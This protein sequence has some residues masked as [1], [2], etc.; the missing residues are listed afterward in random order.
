MPSHIIAA[1]S[2]ETM[3]AVTLEALAFQVMT[4]RRWSSTATMCELAWTKY[5][6]TFLCRLWSGRLRM[7]C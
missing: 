6:C 5:V 3:P 4:H 2:R 7:S 1:E